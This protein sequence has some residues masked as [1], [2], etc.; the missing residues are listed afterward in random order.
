METIFREGLTLVRAGYDEN[1]AGTDVGIHN[2]EALLKTLQQN[3][4]FFE[5]LVQH[6][7]SVE[8]GSI[9]TIH[10]HKYSIGRPHFV[11][12]VLI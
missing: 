2:V 11:H 1:S 6:S 4:V 8:Q 9:P 10:N 7:T 3:S 12:R 5:H